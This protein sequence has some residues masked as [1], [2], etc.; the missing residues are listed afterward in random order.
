MSRSTV[1]LSFWAFVPAWLVGST[2]ATIL[3]ILMQT[4]NVISRLNAIGADIDVGAR[5]SMSAYDLFRLGSVYIIV[6]A[7]GFLGAFFLGI[8]VHRALSFGRLAIFSIAG[9]VAL[10]A[11]QFAFKE[12]YFGIFMIAGA[13]DG[14]GIAMQMIAGAMGGLIFAWLTARKVT[15][16]R[17]AT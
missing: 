5:L 2:I 1:P 14:F 4:Q 11:I 6:I 16:E 13:R 9:A 15:D 3:A 7:I 12:A 10:L 8:L 17:S